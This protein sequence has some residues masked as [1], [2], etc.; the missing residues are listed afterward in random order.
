MKNTATAKEFP[1]LLT[2]FRQGRLDKFF[3]APPGDAE[4]IE[5]DFFAT[6]KTLKPADPAEKR[7]PIPHVGDIFII[8]YT[9]ASVTRRYIRPSE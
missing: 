5:L 1:S 3:M 8:P 4:P 7:Q 6:V 9:E 2:Y